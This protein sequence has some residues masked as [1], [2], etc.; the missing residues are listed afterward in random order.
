MIVY[1]VVF[2]YMLNRLLEIKL[3]CNTLVWPSLTSHMHFRVYVVHTQ[4]EVT[5]EDLRDQRGEF[6]CGDSHLNRT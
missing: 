2:K 1:G 5:V 3:P 4:K 6:I